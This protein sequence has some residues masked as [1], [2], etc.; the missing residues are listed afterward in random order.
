MRIDEIDVNLKTESA[1][2]LSDTVYADVRNEP[3]D[4]YGF[5]RPQTEPR[6]CRMP[7]EIA[8]EAH[9]LTGSGIVELTYHTAGGR[10]RFTTDSPYIEIRCRRRS[11][12]FMPH[13]P[14]S[15]SGGFD[16]CETRG[17]R[18]RQIGTFLPPTCFPDGR[19]IPLLSSSLM[20]AA[21]L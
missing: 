10:V 4:L 7:V 2:S 16:L 12:V 14:L 19:P 11:V 9:A 20:R 5:Y 1:D 21:S 8:E 6:F 18:D 13:M 17:G 15:G 3:F